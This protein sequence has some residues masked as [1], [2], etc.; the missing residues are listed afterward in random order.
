MA[1]DCGCWPSRPAQPLP[2]PALSSTRTTSACATSTRCTKWN[3]TNGQAS[4]VGT[5]RGWRWHCAIRRC[6]RPGDEPRRGALR[7]RRRQQ[8]PVAHRRGR[9]VAPSPSMAARA[10]PGWRAPPVSIS[11]SPSTAMARCSPVRTVAAAC[12]ASTR[13][14]SSQRWSAAKA[15][16]APRSPV[17]AARYDGVYGIGSSNGDENLYRID[18]NRPGHLV[19]RW[20][21]TCSS[22]MAAWI[23]MPPASCGASPTCRA[24]RSTPSR[25]CCSHRSSPPAAPLRWPPR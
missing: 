8:D 17:L 19:G 22:P 11:A 15:P 13:H 10:T 9:L 3:S 6:R 18:T 14:R 4:I 21:A 2:P 20:V 25:A 1:R 5:V 23:L 16:S 12:T 7:H 24:L